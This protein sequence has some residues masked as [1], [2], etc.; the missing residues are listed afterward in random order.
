L[1][2]QQRIVDTDEE[3]VLKT[4]MEGLESQEEDDPKYIFLHVYGR[5]DPSDSGEPSRDLWLQEISVRPPR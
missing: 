4:E 2:S 5:S 3:S 1:R